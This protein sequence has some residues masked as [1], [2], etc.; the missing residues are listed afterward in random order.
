MTKLR[1][2]VLFVLLVPLV[3]IGVY[4]ATLPPIKPGVTLENFRRLHKHMTRAQIEAILG[5]GKRDADSDIVRWKSGETEVAIAFFDSGEAGPGSFFEGGKDVAHL[6]DE[7]RG[8]ES[9]QLWLQ[10]R[11]GW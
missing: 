8:W 1:L 10:R 4:W 11:M 5:T 9:F 7:A 3:G 2:L 6:R